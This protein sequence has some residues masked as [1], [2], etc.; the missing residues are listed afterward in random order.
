MKFARKKIPPQMTLHYLQSGNRQLS[1]ANLL[2]MG[3]RRGKKLHQA[4]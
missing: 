3:E 4:Y 1:L 2:V